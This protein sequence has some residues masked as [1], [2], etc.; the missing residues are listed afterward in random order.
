MYGV[1]RLLIVALALGWCSA[2][3][4]QSPSQIPVQG[5]LVDAEGRALTTEL[6]VRFRLY[7]DAEGATVLWEDTLNVR[8]EAGYF[9]V[10]LGASAPL[11]LSLFKDHSA[12][13]G[14]KVGSDEEMALLHLATVPY[15]AF[16]S[17]AG[18]A[19]TLGGQNRETLSSEISTNVTSTLESSDSFV[20]NTTEVQDAS[21]NISGRGTMGSL[22]VE[23]ELRLG[24]F[25]P[26]SHLGQVLAQGACT[27]LLDT[28]GEVRAIPRTCWLSGGAGNPESC[29]TLC[30]KHSMGCFNSLHVYES[31]PSDALDVPGLRTYVYN[32]CG[33]QCGPN[34]CCCGG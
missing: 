7:D 5:Y 14:I 28:P 33:G 16:A 12:Y 24:S 23:G 2:L 20:R 18:D 30:G 11:D 8:L 1:V 34:Y 21:F 22:E 31:L 19:A 6:G 4:A 27:G 3:F 13:L 26:H 9:T 29:A 10:Y 25:L 17:Y 15:A 32:A